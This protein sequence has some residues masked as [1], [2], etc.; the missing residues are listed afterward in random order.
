MRIA[1]CYEPPAANSS[2]DIKD[3][4]E[5]VTFLE[6]NIEGH[7]VIRLPYRGDPAA[8]IN[9]LKMADVA[10]NLFET[11][12]ESEIESYL[13]A[14]LFEISGM[15][16]TGSSLAALLSTHDKRLVKHILSLEQ[17]TTPSTVREPGQWIIKPIYT[18]GSVGLN[19]YSVI[20]AATV[21]ELNAAL[22]MAGKYYFAE[23][24]IDGE[25]LSVT[26]LDIGSGLQSRAV[27]KME[28]NYPPDKPKILTYDAKWS[29]NSQEYMDSNRSFDVEQEIARAAMR[30][31]EKTA[32]VLNLEGYA[33]VDFRVENGVFYCIDVNSNPAITQ[34]SGFAAAALASGLTIP[35][36]LEF[37]I[38]QAAYE[39]HP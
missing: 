37:I 23:K 5:Q 13:G 8:F 3:V 10:W 21:K 24:Y 15:P 19:D 12:N 39:D 35:E 22:A 25:E 32:R 31:A 28:F 26:L 27:S 34:D 4:E 9:K 20:N 29:P 6:R 11:F 36:T 17:I 1:I 18:H 33:R 14:A 7:Q 2:P 30:I 16:Y 38:R